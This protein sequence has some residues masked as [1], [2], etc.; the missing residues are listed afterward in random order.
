M[1]NT[2]A[3]NLNSQ[4]RSIAGLATLPN[5]VTRVIGVAQDESCTALDLASEID[6]DPA[7]AARILRLVNSTPYGLDSGVTSIPDAAILL[8]FDEVERIALAVSFVSVFGRNREG[9]KMMRMLWRHSVST[10]IAAHVIEQANRRKH[11]SLQGAHLAGLL[12]DIG[13][14]V[15]AIYLPEEQGRIEQLIASGASP[16]EAEREALDGSTHG[17]I[18]AAIASHWGLPHTVVRSI[19]YHHSPESAPQEPMVQATHLANCVVKQL[20]FSNIR[21]TENEA[22]RADA[23][24][25]LGCDESMISQIAFHVGRSR[26]L[27]GAVSAGAM[28]SCSGED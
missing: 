19:Q 9:V 17:D 16:D 24:R 28:F 26:C 13:K 12:H 14:A 3:P 2:C 18:G 7:L 22:L 25:M 23:C 11:P 1:T 8:G 10:S 15:I 20:G 4:L 27:M 5:V 6:L 21:C